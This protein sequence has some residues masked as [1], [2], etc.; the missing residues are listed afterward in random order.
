[1]ADMEPYNAAGF[2]FLAPYAE[3]DG[4]VSEVEDDMP[5]SDSEDSDYF[6]GAPGKDNKP[7]KSAWRKGR[8]LPAPPLQKATVLLLAKMEK[9]DD[10]E[11]ADETQMRIMARIVKC[12]ERGTNDTTPEGEAQTA[13]AMASKL[14]EQHNIS[15][16]EI[17]QKASGS[18]TW[19]RGESHVRITRT[20]GKSMQVNTEAWAWDIA[21]A[22]KVLFDVSCLLHGSG[23]RQHADWVFYGIASNTAMAAQAF[24]VV[25]N[26]ICEWARSKGRA[27]N[28]YCRGVAHGFVKIARDSK[29]K[30]K[31]DAAEAARVER[32]AREAE[33][34][35]DRQRLMSRLKDPAATADDETKPD[36]SDTPKDEINDVE[37]IEDVKEPMKTSDDEN[38]TGVSNHLETPANQYE[39]LRDNFFVVERL[40]Q[41]KVVDGVQYMEVKWFGYEETSWE[42][43]D[44]LLVDVTHIVAAYE[45]RKIRLGGGVGEGNDGAESVSSSL[46]FG[47]NGWS[48]S[49]ATG[50][51]SDEIVPL[52][53]GNKTEAP[54]NKN[55][56]TEY[57]RE[58]HEIAEEMAKAQKPKTTR[59]KYV[60][61]R[62]RNAYEDG[63][64]DAHDIEVKRKRIEDT[65]SE[66]KGKEV[67]MSIKRQ[68]R[69]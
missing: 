2:P 30:E 63:K 4:D 7:P 55:A 20:R 10:G 31:K 40:L 15:L 33:E 58:A 68:K 13:L 26:L 38:D 3:S 6:S 12:R 47:A 29:A 25:Y 60:D 65:M 17:I 39:E 51:E 27:R 54:S 53:G 18:R 23:S 46:D 34:H 48:A 8:K 45:R 50:D 61:I 41:D 44:Q 35:L 21:R 22:I 19:E 59:V 1:V 36:E 64:R 9:Q 28:N 49:D 32:L 66:G 37:G 11:E 14:M 5:K 42:P 52:N 62:D 16:S 43:R 56:L 57:R 24:E 69:E 67:N